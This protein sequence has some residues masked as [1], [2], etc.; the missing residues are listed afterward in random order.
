M[1]IIP[2]CPNDLGTDKGQGKQ[3][4]HQKGKLKDCAGF[5]VSFK[6]LQRYNKFTK[7]NN[8]TNSLTIVVKACSLKIEKK[9]SFHKP[10]L[11]F[12]LAN[13]LF[14]NLLQ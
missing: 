10:N 6:L 8:I 11:I 7:K 1:Y 14:F 12:D 13:T 3:P 9:W 5:Q 4:N 2:A